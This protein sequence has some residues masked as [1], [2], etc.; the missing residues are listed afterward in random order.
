VRFAWISILVIV[1]DQ[2]TKWATPY[3]GLDKQALVQLGN[4]LLML[5]THTPPSSIDLR[6]ALES[7][8]SLTILAALL[9]VHLLITRWSGQLQLITDRTAIGFQLAGGGL[10]SQAIDIAVHGGTLNSF[11]INIGGTTGF[12]AGIAD[13]AMIVGFILLLISLIRG[14]ARLRSHISLSPAN[15]APLQ[16]NLLPR[17]IDNIHIDV[18]LSPGFRDNIT[19][20]IHKVVPMA[21]Q[22]LQQGKRQLTLPSNQASAIRNEF[23]E[24]MSVSLHK[25]KSGGEKQLPDLLFISI[26]KYIH[27]EVHNTV[28]STLQKS[29][30]GNREHRLRGLKAKSNSEVVAWLFRYSE[31]IIALSNRTILEALCHKQSNSLKKAV[32]NF[33]GINSLFTIQAMEAPLVLTESPANEFVQLEHYL[34]LGQQQSAPNSFVSIDRKLTEIFSDYLELVENPEGDDRKPERR[35]QESIDIN[36][37]TI[38]TLSQPSVLMN[39]ENIAVLLDHTW[40]E[41][42]LKRTNKLKNWNKYRKLSQHLHFQRRLREKV[43]LDLK[44][45]GMSTW[46]IASY[47]AKSLLRN[48]NTDITGPNLTALLARKAR[49]NEFMQKLPDA[50]KGLRKPPSEELVLKHWQQVQGNTE[51]LLDKYLLPFIHNFSHYRRDLLRLFIYQRAAGEINLLDERKDIETSRANYTLYEFLHHSEAKTANTPIQS[52]IIIKADLR[53]STEVTEKLTE[54]DLNPA[55]HFD[56]NFFS[57]INNVI[58]SYGAEK[59]FIEGDA[60]ILILNEYAEHGRDRSI[61]ARA[62]GLATNILKIISKQNR[63]LSAYGLPQLELGIGIAFQQGAPRYLYDGQ[64]RIT[65]S[66]AI[67][68]ADRLS[69]CTWSVRNWRSSQQAPD[70]HVEVYQPS[71]AAIGHGEKAQKALVFNLNGILIENNVFERLGKELTLK[72]VGNTIEQI[73]ESRLYAIHFPDLLGTAH[74]LII[75]EAPVHIYDP[76]YSVYDCPAVHGE[77]FYEI[78]WREE[79]LNRLRKH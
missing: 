42:R 66:P 41:R 67:N 78:I 20:L 15:L 29:K 70:N 25:A 38:D 26:L 1:L 60:I 2:V 47:E 49:K 52:H 77:Y 40:T 18:H 71:E 39:P 27:N 44:K 23:K 11:R 21:I 53:G 56:R 24:L 22:A 37:N 68:R 74:S 34:I 19:R 10:A 69:A 73:A 50:L 13:I 79:L 55:T 35:L 3:F 36:S 46:V 31:N 64:H 30:E 61:A 59:V 4:F 65:I 45:S 8:T 12:E 7:S 5:T 63:E 48:T 16:L 57:P 14:N 43:K 9:S 17:G 54:L 58:E 28:A 75:R 72:K 33:L 32:R 51:Q 6:G 76:D 62:C